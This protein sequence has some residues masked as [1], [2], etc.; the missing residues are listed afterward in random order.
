VLLDP[1]ILTHLRLIAARYV[2]LAG[3][4]VLGIMAKPMLVTFPVTLFL[5][6]IWPVQRLSPRIV[7]NSLAFGLWLPSTTSKGLWLYSVA[8]ALILG[9][10][11]VLLCFW[12][13]R[14]TVPMVC[15]SHRV[16]VAG[17]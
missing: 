2:A 8:A 5:L 9:S 4:F 3:V 16:N 6:D 11:P 15:Y 12:L 14:V 1:V 7:M 10:L 17:V 13:A